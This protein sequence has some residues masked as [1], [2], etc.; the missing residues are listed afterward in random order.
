MDNL[1]KF[2]RDKINEE[3]MNHIRDKVPSEHY[4]ISVDGIYTLAQKIAEEIIDEIKKGTSDQH[5][6]GR[7]GCLSRERRR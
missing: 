3:M 4:L 1:T 6:H 5:D 7:D 2:I